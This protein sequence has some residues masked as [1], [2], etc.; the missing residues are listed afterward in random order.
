MVL[1]T[2]QWK[3]E[4]GIYVDNVIQAF[5]KWDREMDK[6]ASEAGVGGDL[7][8]LTTAVKSIT[9]ESDELIDT[10][11]KPGGVIDAIQQEIDTVK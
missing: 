6:V 2:E 9:T 1:S 7:Q 11:T 4:V 10:L 5:A 3:K 8:D